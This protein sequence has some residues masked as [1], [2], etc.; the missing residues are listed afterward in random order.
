M[1][2]KQHRQVVERAWELFV[3]GDTQGLEKVSPVIR[4]SWLRSKA[5]GVDPGLTR[6]PQVVLL[7]SLEEF[8]HHNDLAVAGQEVVRGML[9]VLEDPGA[10]IALSDRE[11]RILTLAMG[12]RI[13]DICA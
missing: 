8:L 2:D 10:A 13:K 7:E 5:L 12:P 1:R 3:S 4:D 11:G 6:I 9:E